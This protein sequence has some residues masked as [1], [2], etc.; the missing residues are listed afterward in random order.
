MAQGEEITL[1]ARKRG[2]ELVE[3]TK[4]SVK[5]VAN[6]VKKSDSESPDALELP[7]E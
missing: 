6:R 2:E 7:A 4:E 5:K 3:T 1:M